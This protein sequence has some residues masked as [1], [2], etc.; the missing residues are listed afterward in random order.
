MSG[1]VFRF[2]STISVRA[3]FRSSAMFTRIPTT[4]PHISF[5]AIKGA[6]H[7]SESGS[8]SITG[9]ASSDVKIYAESKDPIGIMPSTNNVVAT[10]EKP[11]CGM[12]PSAA[13]AIGP[14]YGCANALASFSDP[15]LWDKVSK[16]STRTKTTN[17]AGS[18]V[19][20]WTRLSGN[21]SPRI[22][23]TFRSNSQIPP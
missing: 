16:S 9:K 11:H 7:G 12:M 5:I 19:P 2:S 22:S 15:F 10:T 23:V 3:F 20:V 14:R 4:L 21:T 6:T 17:S 18:M 8:E 13:A 1:R